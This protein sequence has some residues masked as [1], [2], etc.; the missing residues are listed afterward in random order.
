MLNICVI[1]AVSTGPQQILANANAQQQPSVVAVH[2][3]SQ[4]QTQPQ[5][6]VQLNNTQQPRPDMNGPHQGK[7]LTVT[8]GLKK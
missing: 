2:P 5:V 1:Y 6:R 8:L 7:S 3:A 4:H